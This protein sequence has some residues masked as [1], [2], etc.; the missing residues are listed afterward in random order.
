MGDGQM[1]AAIL[2][3]D[4][5]SEAKGLGRQVYPFD[6]ARWQVLSHPRLGSSRRPLDPRWR[7]LQQRR[8]ALASKPGCAC[9]SW[10]DLTLRS[11]RAQVVVCGIAKAVLSQKFAQSGQC[12]LKGTLPFCC[13]P[14]CLLSDSASPLRWDS[15]CAAALE[16][17]GDRLLAEC[18]KNDQVWPRKPL[19]RI[20]CGRCPCPCFRIRTCEAFPS[21]LPSKADGRP[22]DTTSKASVVAGG[23]VGRSGRRG[24]T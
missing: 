11:G 13:A 9:M 8:A 18:T 12:A 17:T 24:S 20:A 7:L 23:P 6:E 2:A 16:A 15:R 19:R 10:C 4:S 1:Y 21:N 5:Q 14:T 22:E 3:A